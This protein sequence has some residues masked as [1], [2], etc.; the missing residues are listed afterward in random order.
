MTAPGPE[1]RPY[2]CAEPPGGANPVSTGARPPDFRVHDLCRRWVEVQMANSFTNSGGALEEAASGSAGSEGSAASAEWLPPA[3]AIP[4]PAWMRGGASF[5]FAANRFE[6]GCGV[7]P[8]RPT[9]FLRADAESRRASYYQLMSGIA[10]E[11]GLPVGVFDAMIIIES[12]SELQ[13][14]MRISYAV[15]CL[16]KKKLIQKE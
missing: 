10:C 15:F 5:Y 4:V 13:S 12:T 8:Y 7:L 6:P 14:L 3:P 9:G 11:Y 2:A 16:K 1:G